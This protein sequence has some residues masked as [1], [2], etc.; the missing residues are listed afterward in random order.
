MT[1]V[2][3]N[4]DLFYR[5][6]QT[7]IIPNNGVTTLSAPDSDQAWQVLRWE[8]ESF[9]CEGQYADGLRR[10][11]QTYL[12]RADEAQ[13]PG[14]WISGFYGSGKSHFVRVL[15]HL[16]ADTRFPDGSSAR[17]LVTVPEDVAVLLR[18]LTTTGRRAGG[19]WAAS[20]TLGAEAEGAVRLAFARIL[21]RAAGLPAEYQQGRLALW[22]RQKGVLD[23]VR[24][25]VERRGEG[26]AFALNNMYMSQPLAAAIAAH[27]PGSADEATVSA[28][29]RANYAKPS[30]LSEDELVHITEDLMA[31]RSDRSGKTPCTLVVLDEVQQYIGDNRE[32]VDQVARLAE[33]VTKRF[34][35][36][37][38]LVATGQSAM[39]A[40]PQLAKIKDRFPMSV[41]LS[42]TD[43]EQVVRKVILRKKPEALPALGD[44]LDRASGEIARHLNGT[45]LA[46]QPGDAPSLASDY[47]LLPTRRR[48]WE[49][50]LR[51]IDRAG[52]T[53]QLRSQLR[54]TH[55]ASREVAGRAPGHVIGADFV[56]RPL[57]GHLRSTSVLLDDTYTLIERLGDGS[58]EGTLRQRVAQLLFIL[59]RLDGRL[60]V[61]ATEGTLA[62][63]LVEDLAAGSGALRARL[64]D[65]LREMVNAGTV[66]QTGQEYRLQTREG[67]E[68]E[69]A[70]RSAYN[71]LK[72]DDVRQVQ[73]REEVLRAAVDAVTRGQLNVTQGASRT[74]RKAEVVYA[75]PG[76]GEKVPVWIR[77]GWA[78]AAQDVRNDA[79]A[80]GSESATVFVFIPEPRREDFREAMTTL[81]AAQEVLAARPVASTPEAQEARTAMQTRVHN[82]KADVDRLIAQAVDAAQVFQAGGQEL[83]GNLRAALPG[84][85]QAAVARL[86]PRFPEGDHAH[87]EK[88][89]RNAKQ[90]NAGAL[91]AVNHHAD[92]L[93]HPVVKAVL[94]DIG[95]GKKGADVRRKFT[96]V[97]YGWPQ[98]A[99]DT[100]LTL[101]TLSGHLRATLNGSPVQAR[102]LDNATLSKSDFRQETVT[103]TK[104]QMLTVRKL[105]QDIGLKADAGQEAAQADEY[106]RR[107][108]DRVSASGGPAPLPEPLPSA[109]VDALRG[110]SGPERLLQM[111]TSSADLLALRQAADARAELITRRV[112]HWKKLQTLLR[113]T[114]DAHLKAQADAIQDGRLLLSDPDPMEPLRT[115]LMNGL[116]GD[117]QA[118]RA[119]YAAAF[120]AGL[121]AL[122]SLPQWTALPEADRKGWLTREN[123]AAPTEEKLGGI[124]EIV[125]ALDSR[126][127]NEWRATTEA[128]PTRFGRLRQAFLQSLEPKAR[129]L[130]PP[131]AT[132][133]TP[134]DVDAY[135]T[136]LRQTLMTIVDGGQPVIVQ[137][138]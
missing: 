125:A 112:D 58:E 68:W 93:T 79:L 102:A 63:L 101:L 108:T 35:G 92:P 42:S 115:E 25:D 137:G 10:L 77:P 127:L 30:D 20:G 15:E 110:L 99:V 128:V 87:W 119:A 4:A 56:Y 17:E 48:L 111:A 21:L 31:L 76:A 60:G 39:G 75:A 124:N 33:T 18:E 5:D 117:L 59:S 65:V 138:E 24:A 135:L 28:Q 43:V 27:V 67:G 57:A 107:L 105:Y 122:G 84:A 29:L 106:L 86:Y 36:R 89:Y 97:E 131:S 7:F 100:A 32:R 3:R 34:G 19:L 64:P 61:R 96:G 132:L 71:A 11:L 90:E 85:L 8:L 54:I 73:K 66:M 109:P 9:V 51:A 50:F 14:W 45:K 6:P 126:S 70:Y 49:E 95:A 113:H 23:E 26:W 13:Q 94:G 52:S 118:A 46:P 98:D 38:L 83:D 22:L 44:V 47:P 80:A 130:R 136:A 114:T 69:S 53:G 88:A 78:E 81:L 37:L 104:G 129:A 41:E 12:T 133:K 123:L 40:T 62:D 55:E 72:D 120:E 121:H 82:A 91:D 1:D 103:L 116:R 16:W 74:A 2:T 134:A